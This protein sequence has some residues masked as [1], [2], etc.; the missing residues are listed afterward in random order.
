V[1]SPFRKDW[2]IFDCMCPA[3]AF[4]KVTWG[5]SEGATYCPGPGK[6][7]RAARSLMLGLTWFPK[8][9]PRFDF[10]FDGK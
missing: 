6:F 8:D 9:L 4:L 2:L 7:W 3:F 10:R 1:P 5:K